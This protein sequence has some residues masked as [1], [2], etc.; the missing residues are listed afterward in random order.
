[1]REIQASEMLAHLSDLLD[2]VERGETLVITRGGQRI[3]QLVP[4][5]RQRRA[6]VAAMEQIEALRARIGSMSREEILTLKD[7]GRKY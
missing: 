7:E 1:M 4:E 5:D 6:R 2:E 3:A